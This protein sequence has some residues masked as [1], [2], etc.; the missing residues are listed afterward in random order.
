M[1]DHEQIERDDVD[2]EPD[3]EVLVD[4]VI[5]AVMD[6]LHA[7]APGIVTAVSA[8]KKTVTAR[9][10]V[11]RAN[12]KSGEPAVP[13][14]P[15]MQLGGAKGGLYIPPTADDPAVLL[16]A[17]RSLDEWAQTGGAKAIKAVDPRSHDATDALALIAKQMEAPTGIEDAVL[18]HGDSV[19]VGSA[20][21][22]LG[23]YGVEGVT[24]QSVAA[25]SVSLPGTAPTGADPA[26]VLVELNKLSTSINLIITALQN[27]GLLS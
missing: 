10:A 15:A 3:L 12:S 22:K 2:G 24:I 27:L 21:G 23:A 6:R 9:P 25:S 7:M 4:R 19:I 8:S 14:V 20:A 1:T 17:D 26:S 16:Y 18:L 5:D 11:Q 13:D